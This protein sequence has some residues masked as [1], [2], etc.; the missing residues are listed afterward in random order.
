M[1]MGHFVMIDIHDVLD[2]MLTQKT[3]S[4]SFCRGLDSSSFSVLCKMY[5]KLLE[6][7]LNLLCHRTLELI[8]HVQ[9]YFCT[10]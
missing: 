2:K 8:P 6:I 1:C 3:F 4:I 7:I 9:L 5:K 10:N